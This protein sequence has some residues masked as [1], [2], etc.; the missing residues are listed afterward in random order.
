MG[1]KRR[2]ATGDPKQNNI[3]GRNNIEYKLYQ[4][5]ITAPMSQMILTDR[6]IFEDKTY[7]VVFAGLQTSTTDLKCSL[8][9]QSKVIRNF[10]INNV[11]GSFI[12]GWSQPVNCLRSISSAFNL[13][14][15]TNRH[16]LMTLIDT[17]KDVKMQYCNFYIRKVKGS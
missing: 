7:K 5:R 10:K 11:S 15:S 13:E 17:D 2:S 4:W 12:F 9:S 6:L 1:F 8:N 3:S 16:S 14:V